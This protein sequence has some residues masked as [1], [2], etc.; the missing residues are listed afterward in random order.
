MSSFTISQLPTQA[1]F[2]QEYKGYTLYVGGDD[3]SPTY[4]IFDS[5]G[6]Y[7][8]GGCED[9]SIPNLEDWVNYHYP[10]VA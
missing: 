7:L 2:N 6:K 8:D 4:W 10:N 9:M 5:H 3:L 1:Q